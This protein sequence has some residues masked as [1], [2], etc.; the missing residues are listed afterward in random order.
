MSKNNKTTKPKH[1]FPHTVFSVDCV[2]QDN[3]V[4][5]ADVDDAM[6]RAVKEMERAE[7]IDDDE[8][9][10]YAGLIGVY[11]LTEV[12]RVFPPKPEKP[13]TRRVCVVRG[14]GGT[15]KPKPKR[16]KPPGG[17]VWKV[18]YDKG[19][20]G[21][22][23]TAHNAIDHNPHRYTDFADEFQERFSRRPYVANVF[24]VTIRDGK[25]SEARNARTG[26]AVR[27]GLYSP[28]KIVRVKHEGK[29]VDLLTL[30]NETLHVKGHP[31]C[32]GV[33]RDDGSVELYTD[34]LDACRN[35]D[36]RKWKR[37]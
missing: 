15:K 34:M 6:L 20:R 7:S 10:E 21:W 28:P 36:K 19:Q 1:A 3:P 17:T 14:E 27:K 26:K 30:N 13:I 37:R 35:A 23:Y 5:F 8:A 2:S 22:Y 33:V 25:I 32:V 16:N 9:N 11:T 29:T 18:W 31:E 4:V 24:L 12:R